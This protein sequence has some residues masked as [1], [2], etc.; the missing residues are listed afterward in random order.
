MSSEIDRIM[1]A[2]KDPGF[3][4]SRLNVHPTQYSWYMFQYVRTTMF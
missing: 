1:S 2:S 3:L 4:T